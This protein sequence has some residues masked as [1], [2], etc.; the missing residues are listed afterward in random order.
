MSDDE[1]DSGIQTS[2]SLAD[3]RK[4]SKQYLEVQNRMDEI[5]EEMKDL[6]ARSKVL[7]EK[8]Q[9]FMLENDY[10]CVNIGDEKIEL[11]H[12]ERATPLGKKKMFECFSTFLNNESRAKELQEYLQNQREVKEY[13]ILKRI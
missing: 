1:S 8:I 5:K 2:M 4:F 13:Y 10:L 3:F 7:S 12:K 11:D 6:K 9:E